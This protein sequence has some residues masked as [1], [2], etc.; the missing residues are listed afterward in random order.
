M[1]ASDTSASDSLSRDR[2]NL[3]ELVEKHARQSLEMEIIKSINSPQS[4]DINSDSADHRRRKIKEIV[5]QNIEKMV[6]SS[7]ELRLTTSYRLGNIIVKSVRRPSFS[8]S[9]L[10]PFK[11][12]R[13]F[14][15]NKIMQR[16][17][18]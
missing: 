12:I 11:I 6:L 5:P 15:E 14:L 8:N 10:L 3:I 13:L 16:F 2:H 1:L 9:I 7:I 18:F 17:D 4:Y